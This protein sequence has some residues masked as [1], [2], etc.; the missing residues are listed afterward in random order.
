MYIIKA[1]QREADMFSAPKLPSSCSLISG[2]PLWADENIKAHIT[3]TQIPKT[4]KQ[5]DKQSQDAG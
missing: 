1:D 3:T 2:L 4:P 5:H